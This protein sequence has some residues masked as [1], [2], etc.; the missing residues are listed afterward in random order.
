MANVMRGYE[1]ACL[2]EVL[3]EDLE[4]IGADPYV[5]AHA[6]VCRGTVVTE[7]AR[8]DEAMRAL[9]N[10]RIPTVCERMQVRCITFHHF[11]WEMR[12]TFGMPGA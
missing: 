4:I 6:A 12:H 7:E 5:I 3:E 10:I 1:A 11:L 8:Q 9:K 2:D